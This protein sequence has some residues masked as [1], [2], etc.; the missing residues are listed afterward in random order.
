MALETIYKTVNSNGVYSCGDIGIST[1]EWLTL[2]NEPEASPYLE[3]LCCFL[4]EPE[5]KGTCS[6][7]A[8]KYGKP[9]AHYNSKVTN[10]SKWV[11]KKLNRFRVMGTDGNDTYWCIAMQKGWD[12]KQGFQWQ[13]RDELAEAL[14]AYLMK[15]LINEFSTKE[16]FNGFEE[17]YKWILLDKTEGKDVLTII[18]SLRGQNIV[19]NARVDGV[20]KS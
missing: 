18:K 4:R 3:A 14:Q 13:L 9:A 15:A 12:T 7:A 19:D 17:E 20:L 10:F 5:H 8:L 16:P 11:Q 1:T 6:I 2:L